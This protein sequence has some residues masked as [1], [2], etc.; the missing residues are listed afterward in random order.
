M[1]S[2]SATGITP[3]HPLH[4]PKHLLHAQQCEGE[5]EGFGV[6]GLASFGAGQ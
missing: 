2:G 6:E 5:D 4:A 3:I 1:N